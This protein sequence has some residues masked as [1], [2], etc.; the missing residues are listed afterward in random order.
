MSLTS[1][2]VYVTQFLKLMSFYRSTR[3]EAKLRSF[4]RFSA[5]SPV[6]VNIKK[7]SIR[8]IRVYSI[9]L[10]QKNI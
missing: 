9:C 2:V 1:N 6:F 3:L 4:T 8:T 10:A 5:T 7:D